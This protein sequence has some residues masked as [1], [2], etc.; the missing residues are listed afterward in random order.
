[1][2]SLQKECASYNLDKYIE[3]LHLLK[4]EGSESL[5]ETYATMHNILKEFA[6][7]KAISKTLKP[8]NVSRDALVCFLNNNINTLKYPC[9]AVTAVSLNSLG[10][11]AVNSIASN[12]IFFFCCDKAGV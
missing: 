2:L 11:R 9:M 5:T 10:Q 8:E 12:V 6:K 3:A 1:M 4:T 7:S